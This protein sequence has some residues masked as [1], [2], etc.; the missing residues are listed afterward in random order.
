M[1]N[2]SVEDTQGTKKESGRTCARHLV[3][4]S[5]D[6]ALVSGQNT[7]HKCMPETL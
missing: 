5:T 7:D 2:H 1:D 3:R 6:Q 4:N